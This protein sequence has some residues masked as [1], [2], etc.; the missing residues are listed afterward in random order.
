MSASHTATG[1]LV[2]E[3]RLAHVLA[4]Q[5]LDAL[6]C[7][8]GVNVTYLS[9]LASPGTLGRHLD[10][11]ETQRE[12]FVVWPATGEPVLL[13]SRIASELAERTSRIA[14]QEVFEDYGGS[15]EQTLAG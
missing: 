13:V 8:G 4:E 10:F 15:A 12:V 1:T 7:R 3:A 9:G 2:N 14:R 5:R 11:A 6:V